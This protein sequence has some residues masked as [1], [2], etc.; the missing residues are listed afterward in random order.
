M[1]SKPALPKGH[2]APDPRAQCVLFAAS[3][4]KDTSISAA[5]VT[6]TPIRRANVFARL[7]GHLSIQIPPFRCEVT[8]VFHA[9]SPFLDWWS[10]LQ[11]LVA[12]GCWFVAASVCVLRMLPAKFRRD[13][14][15]RRWRLGPSI[16][17]GHRRS[18]DPGVDTVV[19]FRGGR[20]VKWGSVKWG[21][22]QVGV[23]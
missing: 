2:Q 20:S 15:A 12:L 19:W 18:L 16:F 4:H 11:L 8:L 5:A 9:V 6:Y 3:P 17:V 21:I 23:G 22:G 14:R 10:P 1:Y 7:L 13:F